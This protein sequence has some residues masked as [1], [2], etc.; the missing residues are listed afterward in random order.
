MYFLGHFTFCRVKMTWPA[1]WHR[2]LR[3]M[4][5]CKEFSNNFDRKICTFWEYSYSFARRFKSTVW[6]CSNEVPELERTVN[7][8][9]YRIHYRFTNLQTRLNKLIYANCYLKHVAEKFQKPYV[10]VYDKT[11]KEIISMSAGKSVDMTDINHGHNIVNKRKQ[12]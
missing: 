1:D 12:V 4:P 7:S 3:K 9:R 5:R 8:L 11:K 10:P 2:V 6:F